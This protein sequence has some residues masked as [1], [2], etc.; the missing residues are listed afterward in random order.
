MYSAFLYFSF[1]FLL[2][3]VVFGV[4]RV[5]KIQLFSTKESS[6]LFIISLIVC[7]ISFAQ[8]QSIDCQID[9]YKNELRI[10]G[11]SMERAEMDCKMIGM[12]QNCPIIVELNK[13][14]DLYTNELKTLINKKYETN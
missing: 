4:I 10:L 5:F 11:G 2:C 12:E 9:K 7:V 1:V 14:K 3:A 8:T 6:I 13:K